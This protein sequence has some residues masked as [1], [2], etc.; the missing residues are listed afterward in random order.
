MSKITVSRRKLSFSILTLVLLLVCVSISFGTISY[1]AV[2]TGS[3]SS[4]EEKLSFAVNS[5]K[6]VFSGTILTPDSTFVVNNSGD[7]VDANPGNGICADTNGNCTLRAAIM[8]SNAKTG[9]DEINFAFTNPTTIQLNSALSPAG[10]IISKNVTINGPGARLL[11][12]KG[13]SNTTSG[14]FIIDYAGTKTTSISGITVANSQGNGIKNEAILNLSDV[15][16]KG[17]H[18]GIYNSGTLVLNRLLISDNSNG[19]GLY[20]TASSSANVSNTTITDNASPNNG[21]GINSVSPNLTLN[22]VT[23]SNNTAASKGGGLYYS[24]SGSGVYIRN[25]IIANNTAPAG[26]DVFS[27]AAGAAFVSRGNNLIGKSDANTGFTNG[28]KGDKVG[29]IAAPIDP[30]LG[31]LQNN[32]GQTDTRALMAGSPA[33]DAGDVCV[34]TSTCTSNG[35]SIALNTDQRGTGFPRNYQN[36]VDIGAFESFYPTPSISSLSSD[37]E[38]T[39]AES[40]ELIVNGSNFVAGSV[41]QWNGEDR[42]TTFVSNTQLKVQILASDLATAGQFSVTVV[43]PQPGDAEPNKSNAVNFTVADCSYSINPTSKNFT[44]AG[45]SGS[46]TVT[47]TNRCAWTAVSDVSWITINGGGNRTGPGTVNFTV[48][49]NNGSTR[50]GTITI[51]GQTFTV[52]Q[53]GGCAYSISPTSKSAPASGGTNNFNITTDSTCSWNAVS[54]VSWITV[55]NASGTGAGTISY[56]VSA[57]T[58]PVRSGNITV[59]GRTFTVNQ[60]SGCSY[61]ISPT[62]KNFE[63]TGGTGNFNVSTETGCSWTAT[64]ASPW[65]TITSGAS[66]SGNGAV[67]FTVAANNGPARNG[68]IVVN[69]QVFNITQDNGCVYSLSSTSINVP[70]SAGTNSFTVNSG[71]GCTWAATSNASW[72]TITSSSNGSGNGTVTFSFAAN[73]GLARSGTITVNGLTF[74]VNQANGCTFSINPTSAPIPIS[75]GNG[76]VNVTSTA[77]GCPWTAQSNDSWITVTAGANGTGNG[78]VTFSVAANNGPARSGTITIAG[79]TFTINQASGCTFTLSPSN[80]SFMPAGGSGSFNITTSNPACPWTAITPNSWIIINNGAS[81]TGDGVVSFT[82]Q[83]NVSPERT[84]TISVNGQLFTITQSN[85]CTYSLPSTS[86]NVPSS[87]GS[88][89]FNV[90]SGA[91]CTWSATS[92][93]SW[94]TITSGSG[95]GSGTVSFSFAANVGPARTGIITVNGQTFTVTQNN[96]CTYLITPT[97]ANVPIS[98]GSV[99]VNVTASDAGCQ[100]TAQSNASWIMLITANVNGTGSGTVQFTVAANTSPERNGTVTIAGHTFTVTQGNGCTYV[101]SSNGVSVNESGGTRSFNI[102][103]GVGCTWTVVSNVSWITITSGSSGSGNGTITFTVQANGGEIRS[104]NITVGGQ[105]FTV[106]QISLTVTNLNDS[107][108]GSLRQAVINANNSPGDDVITFHQSVSGTISLTSGEITITNNGALEIKGPGAYYLTISGNNSSRLFYINNATVNISE[109]TLNRGNGVGADSTDFAA[110]GGAIYAKQ[111][112]LTLNRVQVIGNSISASRG[113]GGAVYVEGGSHLIQNSYFYNNRGSYGGGFF[114]QFANVTVVN[115]TFF[116]NIAAQEGGAIYSAAASTQLRNATITNNRSLGVELKGAGISIHGNVFNM[117]NS[118][119]AENTGPDGAENQAAEITFFNGQVTS[120]GNNLIGESSGDASNTQNTISYRQSDIRDTSPMLATP[121]DYGGPTPTQALLP[122]SPAINAGFNADAPSTDQR[123]STRIVGG[124]IDIGAFENNIAVSPAASVL[125]NADLNIYYS[126]SLSATRLNG[127][128]SESFKF[129]KIDGSLPPGLSITISGLIQGTPTTPGVY[130]FTVHAATPDRMAGANKYTISVSCS[131]SI[132]PT[133]KSFSTSEGSGTINLAASSGC[134]W[135]AVSNAQWIIIKSGSAGTGNGVIEYGVAANTGIARTGTITVGGH[136]FTVNQPSGCTYTLSS[137][138]A[139]VQAGGT[140]GSISINSGAGCNWE[141]RSNVPWITV[142]SN[143]IGSGQI[144]YTVAANRGA[145]RTGTISVN[146]KIFTVNQADGTANATTAYDFDGDGRADVSVY[147]PSDGG[148]YLLNSTSGFT[149][150]RF[151]ASADKITPADFDGDGKTDIAVFRDGTW[152]LQR[153]SLGFFG[154]AFGAATDIPVPADFDGDGKA[155]IAV[156]RPSD[157]VWYIYNLVNS[158][159]TS[160]RF[161][162]S[163]DIPVAADY[164]G[165]GKADVAVY[166]AGTWYVDRSQL[167]FYG[168]TFGDGN[169]KPVPADYDGDGRTDIAVFRPS[170]GVW[171]MQQSTAGFVATLFGVSIDKPAPADYD[172]DGKADLG[173]FREGTWYMQGSR[174]GFTGLAFGEAT[175]KP[176]PNAFIP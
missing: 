167:G 32:G 105:T 28:D 42:V 147:R 160:T 8:E 14:V 97:S 55:N 68:T 95:S 49:V 101:L 145:A 63:L 51:A 3:E 47:T 151:G 162:Q 153:S 110:N 13:N 123:G 166:R 100:W 21:G 74:T 40:F 11:T 6:S 148:W 142:N 108:V 81:G 124:I 116:G 119:I 44:T 17:N 106:T 76:S 26:P 88:S 86:T 15:A 144:N 48:A 50:S 118:I 98:G 33:I 102:T 93:S 103:S 173:V 121:A 111:G 65:I 82:V 165:D 136:T 131:F 36:G 158:Q 146:E 155:E 163:G 137:L 35:P 2:L 139:D 31:P 18:L 52:T 73:A 77:S 1:S 43:N 60:A 37:S 175:D 149:A 7:S 70:A 91:G 46:T 122:G 34:T 143:G 115:S 104:G 83:A 159:V 29:T 71:A 22:N 45:G 157:G 23:I 27:S 25:T 156:F 150:S 114:S 130:S 54:N 79:K 24:S 57:N 170:D 140:T 10:L 154:L 168:F 4:G 176:I 9:T 58:G 59:N 85:G 80:A 89:S 53:D 174:N 129:S 84:G 62:S 67:S 39:G 78:T 172:G 90:N 41:V 72:I 169:D 164:D 171:Y 127:S 126:Q 135:T 75:G 87:A 20:L 117:G 133:N 120:A 38:R 112:S 92:N 161:G 12:V 69:G 19:G 5:L 94:I 141:A 30:M 134:A 64:T 96:G 66:G 113:N 125:P 61:S 16:V 132:D 109:I 56:T 128:T 107:G 99:S 152:Y 138:S